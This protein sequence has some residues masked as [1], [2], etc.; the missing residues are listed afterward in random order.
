MRR[1]SLYL[2]PCIHGTDSNAYRVHATPRA[3]LGWLM[4]ARIVCQHLAD[5]L[6]PVFPGCGVRRNLVGTE[7]KVSKESADAVRMRALIVSAE[8]FEHRVVGLF[9]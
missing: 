6:L 1:L 4:T 5:A 3:R 7:L 2:A 8:K 9:F